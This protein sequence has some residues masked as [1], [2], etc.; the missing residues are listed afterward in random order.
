MRHMTRFDALKTKVCLNLGLKRIETRHIT[1][2]NLALSTNL[3]CEFG[4]LCLT[5][6]GLAK[7]CVYMALSK[8]RWSVDGRVN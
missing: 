5:Q 2:I 6:T 1:H 3:L 7:L 4:P 8:L